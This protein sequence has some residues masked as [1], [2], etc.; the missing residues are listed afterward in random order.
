MRENLG[1]QLLE[2]R[3]RRRVSL[4]VVCEG[5][6]VG[7]DISDEL[8]IGI[9]H[10]FDV[11][12]QESDMHQPA[13]ATGLIHQ[14]RRLLDGVVADGDDQIRL[15]DGIVHVVPLGERRSSHVEVR[16]AGHCA[17]AHLGIEERNAGPPDELRQGIDE[18]GAIAR[19]TDHDERPA[20]CADH[21]AHPR[22]RVSGG[23]R[24]VDGVRRHQRGVRILGR[25][26]LRKLQ[27]HRTG[28]FLHG[29]PE[30]VAH[31]GWNRGSRDDLP[32]HFRQRPHGADDV[33]HLKPGL[34]GILDGLLAREHEHGHGA[35]MCV[36]R[37]GGE[38]ERAG[39][40]GR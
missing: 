18:A 29:H 22:H 36:G 12:G 33:D 20:R 27:M 3:I 35:Q 34:P 32:R 30:G 38:I 6:H 19:G 39:T 16:A 14:E 7:A 10:L 25:N 17:L 40:Q 23:N 24:P 1:T 11:G 2:R 37:A 9:E 31:Q 13:G 26:V 21:A 28:T 15:V 5:Q 4:E 8:G